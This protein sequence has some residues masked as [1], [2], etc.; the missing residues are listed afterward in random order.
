MMRAVE[1]AYEDLEFGGRDRLI[2][3]RLVWAKKELL[4]YFSNIKRT[5]LIQESVFAWTDLHFLD[6]LPFPQ[7]NMCAYHYLA[8]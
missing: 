1:N 6:S 4:T 8:V 3:P 2:L 5:I 7:E